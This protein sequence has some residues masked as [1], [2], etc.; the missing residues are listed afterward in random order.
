MRSI[1]DN[2]KSPAV[3]ILVYK[4]YYQSAYCIKDFFRYAEIY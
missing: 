1:F 4:E 2:K 3:L